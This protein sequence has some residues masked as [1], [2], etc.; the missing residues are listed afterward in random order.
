MNSLRLV[1]RPFD[2]VRVAADTFVYVG[3]ADRAQFD[4]IAAPCTDHGEN[5]NGHLLSKWVEGDGVRVIFQHWLLIRTAEAIL[6]DREA[7]RAA[8]GVA[9]AN[10]GAQ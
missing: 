3:V 10:G 9:S 7:E 2:F 4:L 8:T 6:A 5:N 1:H